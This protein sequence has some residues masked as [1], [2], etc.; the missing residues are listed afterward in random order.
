MPRNIISSLFITII[1]V[2]S[3][4]LEQ[5]RVTSVGRNLEWRG[6]SLNGGEGASA[7]TE[8]GKIALAENCQLW[9]VVKIT[10]HY[11]WQFRFNSRISRTYLRRWSKQ[12]QNWPYVFIFPSFLENSEWNLFI[13][14]SEFCTISSNIKIERLHVYFD[15][16]VSKVNIS[17]LDFNSQYDF[18]YHDRISSSLS[19]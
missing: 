6:N 13:I 15:N 8:G 1:Q 2:T 9:K 5:I 17:N 11:P 14:I 3:N 7:L 4:I 19:Q 18:F 10:I 12:R 16:I